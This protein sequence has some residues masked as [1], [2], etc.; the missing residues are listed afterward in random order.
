MRQDHAD[1]LVGHGVERFA[2][3]L[4]PDGPEL[5]VERHRVAGAGRRVLPHAVR[6][7]GVRSEGGLAV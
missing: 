3:I 2:A 5:G 6:A 4:D 7:G 1:D